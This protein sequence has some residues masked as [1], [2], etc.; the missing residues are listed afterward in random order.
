MSAILAYDVAKIALKE[1]INVRVE[2]KGETKI[3]E[4]SDGRLRINELLPADFGYVN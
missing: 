1:P 4:T 2:D 3:V